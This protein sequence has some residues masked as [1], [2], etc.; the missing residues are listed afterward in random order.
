MIVLPAT[1]GIVSAESPHI[2]IT[3]EKLDS[4]TRTIFQRYMP[5]LPNPSA[6]GTLAPLPI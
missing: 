6:S 5:D 2:P 1:K 3:T 4:S